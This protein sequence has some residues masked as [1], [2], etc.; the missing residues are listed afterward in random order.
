M[1][2]F[3]NY[4][5]QFLL[6]GLIIVLISIVTKY[7][8]PE[9]A[10][11]IYAIPIQFILALILLKYNNVSNQKI[12]VFVQESIFYSTILVMFLLILNFL[13]KRYSF[14]FSLTI[15]LIL[16]IIVILIIYNIKK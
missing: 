5:L 8:S 13:L 9:L 7:F 4:F 12:I 6:G 16:F 3:I 1:S 10:A 14:K 15:S 2:I 11:I